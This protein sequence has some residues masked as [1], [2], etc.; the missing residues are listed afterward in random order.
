[1]LFTLYVSILSQY[2]V[3]NK[4]SL[5]LNVGTLVVILHIREYR[6]CKDRVT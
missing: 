2:I 6:G 4:S 5:H 1:M 3:H